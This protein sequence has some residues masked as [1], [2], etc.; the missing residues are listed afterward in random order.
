MND[1]QL[2]EQANAGDRAAFAL[3]LERHYDLIYRLAYRM[4]GTQADAE[5]LA[6]DICVA[7]PKKL[8]SFA[9]KSKLTTWL[10]QVTINAGRDFLRRRSTIQKIH[11]Q[12][13]DA[14][15][16][17]KAGD[18]E[19]KKDVEWAYG[20]INTLP[21]DLRETALLVVAEGLIHADAAAILEIKEAT[22]SWRM[23]KVRDH[24]KAIALSEAKGLLGE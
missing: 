7:L 12:F 16:L 9:G 22:V 1:N 15:A 6:Q 5:D 2:A 21:D 4:L 24:L 10:Y 3:L 23:M 18:K 13:M 11:T 14:D 20:A 8:K 19:R 17:Q